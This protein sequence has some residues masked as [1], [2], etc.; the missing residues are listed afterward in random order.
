MDEIQP[1]IGTE[2]FNYD[3]QRHEKLLPEG[4][5]ATVPDMCADTWPGLM[6]GGPVEVVL[7]PPAPTTEQVERMAIALFRAARPGSSAEAWME[8][9]PVNKTRFCSM[10]HAALK[11]E[12]AVPDDNEIHALALAQLKQS[13]SVL[14]TVTNQR[15]LAI[16][17][18]AQ[19][20]VMIIDLMNDRQRRSDQEQNLSAE[21]A[22]LRQQL[23]LPSE[24]GNH[25]YYGPTEKDPKTG[26]RRPIH[27]L[28]HE[29]FYAAV[30]DVLAGRINR[31]ARRQM[32]EA[33][34]AAPKEPIEVRLGDTDDRRRMG[35]WAD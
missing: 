14:E 23:W 35:T 20:Q 13:A 17:S 4:W 5:V 2:R 26:E 10:A 3:M 12:H 33:L 18:L 25:P 7:K 8:L 15:D 30:G 32:Q 29:R 21:V 19:R 16:R 27:D 6:M 28:S 9:G 24:P 34:K 1:P 11:F 31:D 22:Q